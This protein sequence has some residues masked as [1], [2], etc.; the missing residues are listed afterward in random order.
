VQVYTELRK[1]AGMTHAMPVAVRHLESM[2]RM[3]EAHARMHLRD[4]VE[5]QDIDIAIRL[6]L[7]SFV[8]VRD[9]PA[10]LLPNTPPTGSRAQRLRPQRVSRTEGSPAAMLE[11]SEFS[12]TV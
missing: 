7:E 8:Q 6:M 10:F 12:R 11:S 4:T 3:S 9:H 2:I 1:E 5:P